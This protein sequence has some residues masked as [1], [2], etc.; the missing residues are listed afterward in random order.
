MR[1]FPI[2]G[3]GLVLPSDSPILSRCAVLVMSVTS[4]TFCL[5]E[6]RTPP[7]YLLIRFIWSSVCMHL[8][9]TEVVSMSKTGD[10]YRIWIASSCVDSSHSA[11][12]ADWHHSF[13]LGLDF[14]NWS[15][16]GLPC[17]QLQT[18]DMFAMKSYWHGNRPHTGSSRR[19][20]RLS[21]VAL[22]DTDQTRCIPRHCN[23]A[24]QWRQ[25]LLQQPHYYKW[26]PNSY[27]HYFCSV[28][29]FSKAS[30]DGCQFLCGMRNKYQLGSNWYLQVEGWISVWK[31]WNKKTGSWSHVCLTKVTKKNA[32]FLQR[33]FQEGWQNIPAGFYGA[34]YSTLT[35]PTLS[36]V[37]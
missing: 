28:R 18:A 6:Y 34:I 30:P 9:Y 22:H 32:C 37:T 13:E 21:T 10:T 27:L 23:Y 2:V 33:L 36:R 11:H 4:V 8:R 3:L 16:T 24:P 35:S 31:P 7:P 12:Q 5:T 14:K 25:C 19:V 26:Q 17:S 1:L 20:K 15:Y 29:Q